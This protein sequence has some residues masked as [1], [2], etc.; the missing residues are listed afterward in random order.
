MSDT[1]DKTDPA[2]SQK[3]KKQRQKGSVPSGTE[4]AGLL[5]CAAGL[6]VL[7]SMA[8]PIWLL[9]SNSI[10]DMAAV[11]NLE[12]D[13]ILEI[14]V[15]LIGWTILF[16]IGPLVGIIF[17]VSFTIS[18][19]YNGGFVFS[20]DPIKPQLSRLSVKNGFTRI[21]GRRGWLEFGNSSV[22]LIV[23]FLLAGFIASVWVPEFLR[24]PVCDVACVMNIANPLAWVILVAAIVILVITSGIEA[25]IQRN[26]FLHE[27]KMTKSE[28]KRERKDQH[29]SPETRKER[30]RL[31][32]KAREPYSKPNMR[33]GNLCFYAG[34]RAIVLRYMPPDEQDPYLMAKITGEEPVAK[35]RKRMETPGR[36]QS[37][38]PELLERLWKQELGDKVEPE[39]LDML[40]NVI[41]KIFA[42]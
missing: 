6:L 10:V 32:K 1:E 3:L 28:V 7:A 26:Q 23:W 36:Y 30:R 13:N 40:A 41:R 21:F 22:R 33:R 34:D 16:V 20:M 9:L 38:E 24:S 27:Q 19:L 5:G 11:Q 2:S 31:Q 8:G 4:V 18:L 29:G 37:E 14:G 12:I 42:K 17:T 15:Q 39:H 25:V 35:V